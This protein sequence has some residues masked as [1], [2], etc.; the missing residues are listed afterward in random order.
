MQKNEAMQISET[1]TYHS[2]IGIIE[3]TGT[4]DFI[5]A[6]HIHDGEMRFPEY[7]HLLEI[8]K[9]KQ[10][11]FEYFHFKRTSFDL[12]LKELKGTEFQRNVWK[13]LRT[14]PFGQTSSYGEIAGKIGNPKASRAVGMA[15]N[16]NPILIVTPCHRVI[17]ATGKMVGFGGGIWRKEYLLG[18]EKENNVF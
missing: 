12:N 17:G 10:Q 15:N 16:K 6:I 14:I 4:N 5:S 9:C 11:L 18:L 8:N 3:I 13:A 7:S 2:P 1:I